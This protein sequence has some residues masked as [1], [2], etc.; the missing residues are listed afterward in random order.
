MKVTIE[1]VAGPDKRRP[2]ESNISRNIEAL[3]RWRWINGNTGEKH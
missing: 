3:D 1:L 2:I